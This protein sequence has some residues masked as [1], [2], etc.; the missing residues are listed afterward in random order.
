MCLSDR[1]RTCVVLGVFRGLLCHN[2]LHGHAERHCSL[3]YIIDSADVTAT[4][5]VPFGAVR[6]LIGR[7]VTPCSAGAPDCTGAE[8]AQQRQ[9]HL[10]VH[11]NQCIGREVVDP[12]EIAQQVE[13][14]LQ[15]RRLT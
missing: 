12:D 14:I 7:K 5:A 2:H 15:L 1:S 6:T 11:C 13:Q 3:H 10:C 9:H 4:R 8:Q